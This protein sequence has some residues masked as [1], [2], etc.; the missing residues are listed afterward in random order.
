MKKSV[1]IVSLVM[2]LAA[3]SSVAE[4]AYHK[5]RVSL[6]ISDQ[7]TSGGI[8]SNADN[9]AISERVFGGT[10][11]TP[12]PRPDFAATNELSVNDGG[13]IQLGLSYGFARWKWGE[14]VLD[15]SIGRFSA[16]MGN[17]E[18]S[19][20]F[21][22]TGGIVPAANNVDPP[23]IAGCGQLTKYH[24][25]FI[26]V[27]QL[28]Q[29]PLRLSTT[30][31]FRPRASGGAIR[32]MNPYVG[33]GIGYLFV[34][35]DPTKEFLELS[36]NLVNSTGA[37]LY[38]TGE[39]GAGIGQVHR[40]KPLVADTP[41]TFEYHTYAGIDFPVTK[42]LIL[43]VEGGWMWANK[44]MTI[45][46][47]GRENFGAATPNGNTDI[48][49]PDT[50]TPVVFT[51]GGLI[52]YGRSGYYDDPNDDQP[53]RVYPYDPPENPCNGRIVGPKDG[54]PDIGQY[55]IQGGTVSYDGGWFGLGIRYQW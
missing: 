9:A 28:T 48:K 40:F 32:G 14:L 10:T 54:I 18:V 45:T 42:G 17:L 44:E 23:N 4:E 51:S 1:L 16:K 13:L 12:D 22:G 27:G 38:A 53:G 46:A 15:A 8:T 5:Y 31:R 33:L 7:T 49:Y 36:N 37:Y 41:D 29:Y 47:D 25:F 19:G 35:L 30:L 11:S 20:Q 2:V 50:G 6:S 52:D 43:Y 34:N 21:S 55:Y 26:P 39:N 3:G 24:A